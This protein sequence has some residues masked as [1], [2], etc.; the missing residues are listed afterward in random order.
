MLRAVVV[1]VAI[2]L[3]GCQQSRETAQQRYVPLYR[4]ARTLDA[5]LEVG[6]PYVEYG[7]L[8][9]RLSTEV[10]VASDHAMADEEREMVKAYETALT[11][12]KDSL[13]VWRAKI[14]A[15]PTVDGFHTSRLEGLTE[16]D[17]IV[18]DEIAA[19][20]SR[21]NIGARQLYK[22][23]P[24]KAVNWSSA[25]RQIWERAGADAK[26][27]SLLYFGLGVKKG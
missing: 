24:W 25:T 13:S 22:D 1:C 18:T 3:A 4:A 19:I 15:P 10:L 12:Y 27:A 7:Q 17:F 11:A 2:A 16:G 8:V 9:Q 14:E 23:R 6:V 21:Y 20:L 5:A 26:K